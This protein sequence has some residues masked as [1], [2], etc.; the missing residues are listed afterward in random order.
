[1]QSETYLTQNDFRVVLLIGDNE[2]TVTADLD[3]AVVHWAWA[4]AAPE[5]LE[6]ELE[7]DEEDEGLDEE[8]F[9]ESEDDLDDSLDDDGDASAL[10][11]QGFLRLTYKV[12]RATFAC[13]MLVDGASFLTAEILVADNSGVFACHRFRGVLDYQQPHVV[14]QR[15]SMEPMTDV[16]CIRV[17]SA[18]FWLAA[19]DTQLKG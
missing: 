12:N 18:E 7:I 8:E 1:M 13:R 3:A 2:K 16:L 10:E 19:G 14:G 9:N 15:G 4:P 17:Y 5:D 11:L 6:A